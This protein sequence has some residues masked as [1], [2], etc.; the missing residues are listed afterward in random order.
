MKTLLL[1]TKCEVYGIASEVY[2]TEQ[3]IVYHCYETVWSAKYRHYCKTSNE[4]VLVPEGEVVL[5]DTNVNL[6]LARKEYLMG[7]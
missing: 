2:N 3:G 4:L 7:F 1:S 6:I 5:V